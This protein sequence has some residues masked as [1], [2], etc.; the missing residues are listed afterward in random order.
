[1]DYSVDLLTTTAE[2]DSAL[3]LAESRLRVLR[4]RES[5]A[6]YQRENKELGATELSA[7]LA[8]LTAEIDFLT[9]LIASLPA[10]EVRNKRADAL[11]RATDRHDELVSR[12]G[13]VGPLALL[14][15]ELEQGETTARIT[16]LEAFKAAIA[17]RRAAL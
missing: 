2:C 11:R 7:E 1:M 5:A 13:A 4:Q 9:P 12:R 14:T 3:E 10:S 17:A 15:R 8:G 16:E 6:S